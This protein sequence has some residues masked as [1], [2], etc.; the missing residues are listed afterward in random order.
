MDVHPPHQR[1][2]TW[3]DFLLHLLTITVGL[4]IALTLE[5]AV[6]SRHH[7]SLVREA[8]ENLR[9][10]IELNQKVYAKNVRDLRLNRSQ[11]ARDI[12]QLRE[13][14]NGKKLE[15]P[16][17]SWSWNW[18][19][20]GDAAWKTARESGAVAYMDSGWIST[21]S[22]VYTQ[23]EYV[24]SMALATV[25]EETRASAPLQVAKD[26]SRLSPAEI[27]T[28]LIKSA[29]I[30]LSFATLETWMKALDDMYADAL[31]KH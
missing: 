9:R 11:L 10:E 8:H 14:R 12:D 7:R 23:Q 20:Y 28:L 2:R 1:I 13:L 6:E 5:A 29:E 24:N 17:L 27:E 18:D 4:F 19:S 22:W 21:Y 30:D 16:S 26:P 15:N 31:K 3:K 25:H